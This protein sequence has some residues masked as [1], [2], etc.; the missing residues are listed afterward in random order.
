MGKAK[1]TGLGS[2][3][4]GLCT[5]LCF[6]PLLPSPSFKTR[7]WLRI[8][9]LTGFDGREYGKETLRVLLSNQRANEDYMLEG[10]E[11]CELSDTLVHNTLQ[12]PLEDSRSYPSRW[13]PAETKCLSTRTGETWG[14]R[15]PTHL[16]EMR[17]ETIAETEPFFFSQIKYNCNAGLAVNSSTLLILITSC[18]PG[19]SCTSS[20]A[21]AAWV[22]STVRLLDSVS[23]HLLKPLSSS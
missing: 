18:N 11:L 16:R 20:T 12:R 9:D 17:D 7:C 23:G 5:N 15:L 6:P 19:P 13:Q 8:L 3:A 1:S 4:G 21:V 10:G 22:T 14:S 2:G